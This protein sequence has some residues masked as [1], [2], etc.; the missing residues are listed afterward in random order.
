MLYLPI[1]R[2]VFCIALWNVVDVGASGDRK[3]FL[4]CIFKC[5]TRIRSFSYS[6]DA[7]QR[8]P[9][10]SNVPCESLTLLESVGPS[11]LF[12]I[13]YLRNRERG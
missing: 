3:E 5:V 11:V 12:I 7:A 8:T 10:I 1:A 4:T 2:K 6:T 13:S 9:E